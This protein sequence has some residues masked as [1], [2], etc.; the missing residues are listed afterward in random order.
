MV[1]EVQNKSSSY[2]IIAL[3]LISTV[4]FKVVF[5]EPH[6]LSQSLFVD[7]VVNLAL[8]QLVEQE[9]PFTRSL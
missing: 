4:N 8:H 2:R 1:K 6:Q 7:V 9:K 3:L 5:S